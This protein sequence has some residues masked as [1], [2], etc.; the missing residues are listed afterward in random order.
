MSKHDKIAKLKE[1]IKNVVIKELNKDDELEE[2]ST[3]GTAGIDGTGT[4][5]YDTPMAF[6]GGR[7]KDKLILFN[8]NRNF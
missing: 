4:G 6:S 5:H 7:K 3:T 8:S 1:Y 2:V